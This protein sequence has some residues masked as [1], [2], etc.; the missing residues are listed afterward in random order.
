MN[1]PTETPIDKAVVFI[2]NAYLWRIQRNQFQSQEIN[3]LT[4]SNR[5]ISTGYQRLR[6][7]VYDAWPYRDRPPTQLQSILYA[8]MQRLEYT[9]KHY[10]AFEVRMGTQRPRETEYGTAYV[11]KGVDVFLAV[12]MMRLA[13]KRQMQKAV[14]VAGDAD[15]VPL[16]KAIKDEG[17]SVTLYHS[18][19]SCSDELWEACDERYAIT[20]EFIDQVKYERARPTPTRT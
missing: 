18:Q 7:Y 17:V 3:H 6:T 14:L 16:V 19:I 2:D 20:R 12:D 11:Q 5:I 8:K 13:L 1:V 4:L 9:L 10:P 15:Y